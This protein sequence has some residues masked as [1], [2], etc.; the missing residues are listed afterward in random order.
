MASPNPGPNQEMG[1]KW[2]E[3]IAEKVRAGEIRLHEWT[4]HSELDEGVSDD[5]QFVT[6][7]PSGHFRLY[8]RYQKAQA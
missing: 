2:L 8:V 3:A 4:L 7:E 1:A 6:H 5:G